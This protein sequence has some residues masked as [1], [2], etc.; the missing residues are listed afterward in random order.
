[1]KKVMKAKRVS[2]I[3][4]G[5]FAKAV[6]FRG[7]KEKTTGGLTAAMLMTNKRG[8]I[9]SKKSHANGLRQYRTIKSWSESVVAARKALA[10]AGFVAINGKTPHWQGPLHKGEG[11]VH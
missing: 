6:V 10:V 5:K 8:K 4:K 11:L 7:S 2:K 9:V 3:A 1:M